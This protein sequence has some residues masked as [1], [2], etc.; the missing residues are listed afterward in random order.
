MSNISFKCPNCSND[1]SVAGV[2]YKVCPICGYNEKLQSL[3]GETV[4]HEDTTDKEKN[5][6]VLNI[7]K[8]CTKKIG[9]CMKGQL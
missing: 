8:E 1:V 5:K 7:I 9:N 2:N 6:N 3:Q 4:I